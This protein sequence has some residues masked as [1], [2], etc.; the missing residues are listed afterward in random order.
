MLL[1]A[2]SR[3][4]LLLFPGVV[5]P[6][7]AEEAAP[8]KSASQKGKQPHAAPAKPAVSV[9]EANGDTGVSHVLSMRPSL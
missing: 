2:C 9:G 8:V 3:P 5:S 6:Q 7:P 4:L 1:A